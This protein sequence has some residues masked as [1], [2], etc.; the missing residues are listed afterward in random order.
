MNLRKS[1]RINLP[2][3][4]RY[5]ARA[6]FCLA[7]GGLALLVMFWSVAGAWAKEPAKEGSSSG[8]LFEQIQFA[9]GSW[10]GDIELLR[11]GRLLMGLDSG[12]AIMG[13]F[14]QDKGKTWESEFPLVPSP[15]PGGKHGYHHS[16]FTW[17][18]DNHLLLSYQYYLP[19]TRPVYKIS[20]YRRS[21][22]GGKTWGDQLFM[23]FDGLFNDKPVRLSS[24]RLIA[25]V[26]READAASHDH[27]GYASA[28]YYSDDNG[29]GWRESK[30]EVNVLPIEAQEPHVVELKDERLM[31]L[32]RTYS[33]FVVRSYSEDKGVTWSKGESL[34]ELKLSNASSALNVKRIPSTGDLLLLRTTGGKSRW[35]TPFVSA[36]STD[37]GK[38][39]TNERTIAGDPE[40]EESYGYPCLMF[41]D[42]M[43]IIGYNSKAGPHVARIGIDWFYGK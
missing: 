23:A 10:I 29:Y 19:G 13:R 6:G 33:G 27:S 18:G 22:D 17:V 12:G 15:K 2:L 40:E 43:A 36:I 31:M 8:A 37:D 4:N 16:S 32:C 20:Y 42:R 11:D 41:V 25:P 34:K 39:W 5:V 3:L 38:T 35:R 21:V 9:K 14:S 7:L 26:E 24:G 30:N 1:V 28:V